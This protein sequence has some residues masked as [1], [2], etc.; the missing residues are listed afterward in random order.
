MQ[1]SKWRSLTPTWPTAQLPGGGGQHRGG[2]GE[3]GGE[4]ALHLRPDPDQEGG[5]GVVERQDL[6]VGSWCRM[7]GKAQFISQL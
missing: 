1:W 6:G 4:A 7:P 2:E 5:D 3:D